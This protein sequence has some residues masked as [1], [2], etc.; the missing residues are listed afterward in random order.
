MALH[1]GEYKAINGIK[2]PS[3]MTRSLNDQPF[4][5]MTIKSYKINPSFKSN[6]FTKP[7]A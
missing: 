6:T 3:T 5:E 7:K 2:L 4:E 1:L